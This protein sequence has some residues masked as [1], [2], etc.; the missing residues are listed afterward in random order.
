VYAYGLR[1]PWRFSFDR[2]TGDLAIGDVGQDTWEE[3]D[4]VR[5]GRGK[6]ANFGWRPFEGPDPYAPGESAA[7]HVPPVIAASHRNGNCAIIGGVVV[8]DR[9][10]AL[11]GRYLFGDLCRGRIFS[12]RLSAARARERRGTSL[13][14]SRL[15]SVG[16]DARARVY[17]TSYRGGV[18][19]IA[20][21]RPSHISSEPGDDESR[22]RRDT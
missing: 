7:G 12:A 16:E 17:V 10:V 13:R 18:Y 3:I 14:I 5:R 8:R 1:N 9:D 22:S 19:R 21:N 2:R 4:F 20:A 6:G 11:R 15:T